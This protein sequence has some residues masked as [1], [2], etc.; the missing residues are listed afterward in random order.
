MSDIKVALYTISYAGLMYKG[1]HVPL[2]ELIPKIKAFGYDGIEICA[3][4]PFAFPPDLDAKARKKMGELAKSEGIEI[5]AIAGYN[6]FSSPI[7]EEVE[8]ELLM[9]REQIRLASDLGAPIVRVFGAWKGVTIG[10]DGIA[11]WA[12]SRD[13]WN[14]PGTTDI[15]QWQQVRSCLKE[16]CKWAE[17]SGV[18]LAL[19]TH[20]PVV[21]TPGYEDTLQMIK[22]VNSDYL[23][24]S[25]DP[26]GWWAK[27][28]PEYVRQAV[29]D[30]REYIIHSH[31]SSNY[32][33]T[34]RGEVIQVS[35]T[36]SGGPSHVRQPIFDFKAFVSELKKIGYNGYMSYEACTPIQSTGEGPWYSVGDIQGIEEVDRR[37]KLAVKYMKKIIAEA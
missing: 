25:L 18:T 14:Y 12:F 3:K 5:C 27:Q 34:P 7:M 36:W 31:W 29:K 6:N 33:E 9:L 8:N 24:M 19:Q 28:T 2:K 35:Q 1:P 13:K 4:R 30:C 26:A 10:P 32:A 37:V 20:G 11:T 23:K 15:K 21:Q 22:E 16:G 17:E